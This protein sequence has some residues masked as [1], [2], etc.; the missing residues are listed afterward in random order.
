MSGACL[1]DLRS[2]R[3]ELWPSLGM[4]RGGEEGCLQLLPLRGGWRTLETGQAG[5]IKRL[6]SGGSREVKGM[7]MCSAPSSRALRCARAAQEGET[8]IGEASVSA[9]Q[10]AFWL[11]RLKSSVPGPSSLS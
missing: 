11:L 8:K 3:G 10:P 9:A 6:L 5:G 2:L 4:E 7:Q 1:R